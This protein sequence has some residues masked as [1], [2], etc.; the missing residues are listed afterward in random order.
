MAKSGKRLAKG[1]SPAASKIPGP[2]P[3]PMT[4]LIL[5]D[6]ALRA[7]AVLLRR[8]VEKGLVGSALG[9]RKAG[10]IVKGR[11]IF[12]T[13]VGSAIARVATRSVPGAIIVGGSLV[14]KSLYDRNKQRKIGVDVTA[15]GAAEVEEQADRGKKD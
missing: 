7:G 1:F 14:A 6:I 12:Q 3:N 9:A 10:N 13:L 5:T 2:S 8:G 11:S 4:N 15:K